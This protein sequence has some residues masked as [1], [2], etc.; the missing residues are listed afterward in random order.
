M[1]IYTIPFYTVFVK[2]SNGK[3]NIF[4]ILEYFFRT[5]ILVNVVWERLFYGTS[6]GMRL[7]KIAVSG[8]VR[9][10]AGRN[11]LSAGETGAMGCRLDMMYP[12]WDPAA[13]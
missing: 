5:E 12:V 2:K 13:R 4:G 3:Q 9:L 6:G 7:V 10:H 11:A 8:V 1:F